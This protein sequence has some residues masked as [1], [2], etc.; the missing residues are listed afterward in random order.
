MTLQ[1]AADSMRGNS[2]ENLVASLFT[3]GAVRNNPTKGASNHES[4]W[5]WYE[6]RV[7]C[8]TTSSTANEWDCS[9]HSVRAK[10]VSFSSGERHGCQK[11]RPPVKITLCHDH[12]RPLLR[13]RC[14][15]Q[16]SWEQAFHPIKRSTSTYVEH[17]SVNTSLGRDVHVSR[18][19]WH[20]IASQVQRQRCSRLFRETGIL[21]YFT[22]DGTV[23][24]N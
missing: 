12:F 5:H 24:G 4:S 20:A 15:H 22:L 18:L 16:Q 21:Q 9:L 17:A 7:P 6:A 2:P 19:T 11:L 23:T 1:L 3:Y 10:H 13:V 8:V 14:L